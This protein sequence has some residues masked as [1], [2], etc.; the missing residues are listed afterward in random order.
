MD[1][2]QRR[3]VDEALW[4]YWTAREKAAT[5]QR[6]RGVEDTGGR[7][8]STSGGHLDQIAHLLAGAAVAAG[9]PSYEV[10]YKPP[11][12][13]IWAKGGASGY[14]LPGYY[15]PTKQW[16]VVVWRRGVPI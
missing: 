8:G 9:A 1:E 3:A 6:D 15:R 5:A 14:T 4:A 16:D 13:T 12:G 2:E 10:F 7:S 11:E